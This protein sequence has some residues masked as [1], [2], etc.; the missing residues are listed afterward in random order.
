MNNV[1]QFTYRMMVAG[2]EETVINIVTE[3][4]NAFV[5]PQYEEGVTEFYKYA[6]VINLAERSKEIISL[7]LQ[8]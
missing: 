2:E 5:A 4:F 6:N 3:V 1:N 8:S 7:L